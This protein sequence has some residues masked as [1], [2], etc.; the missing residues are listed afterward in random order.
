MTNAVKVCAHL[1]T[2][3]RNVRSEVVA[4]VLATV[5]ARQIADIVIERIPVDV[6]DM[7]SVRDVPVDGLPE[8]FVISP[9]ATL[10]V[11]VSGREVHTVAALLG[12][13]IAPEGDAIEG[14]GFDGIGGAF[15]HV[16][17]LSA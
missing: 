4:G 12:E 17:R 13:R 8:F 15:G 1:I 3:F 2:V 11:C 16:A 6:V 7:V 9:D 14:D 10:T 5:H